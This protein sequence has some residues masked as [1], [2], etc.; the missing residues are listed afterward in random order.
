MLNKVLGLLL[1]VGVLFSS[2][3]NEPRLVEKSLAGYVIGTTYHI[4][5][6]SE[7]GESYQVQIDSVYDA[8]I[9][10]MSTYEPTSDISKI[11]NGDTNIVVDHMFVDVYKTS[12]KIWKETD[13]VFDPTIGIMVNAWGFGPKKQLNNLNKAK[14]IQLMKTVGFDK[15]RILS[16]GFF[17]KDFAETQIDFNAIAKGYTLDRVA[18]FFNQKGLENYLIEIG[19]EIVAKG[20]KLDGSKWRIGID[21][22]NQNEDRPLSAIVD[23]TDK[24][25]ATSGNYRRFRVDSLTGE[26][27][28]HTI[29]AKTGF[30]SRS[31]I[32][33]ASVMAD[34]C[35]LAD[36]YATT[37]MAMGLDDTK[38]FLSKHP[39]LEA[40]LIYVDE[41]GN[42]KKYMT[43]EFSLSLE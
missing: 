6:L 33:S 18:V 10:S 28:V 23:I 30:T 13:G 43:K 11:N 41:E 27:Y 15:T 42:W 5:Y 34:N 39:E 32:L 19:G 14:V 20:V 1:F 2:C 7:K 29:N 16:N 3:S 24:A 21:D 38:E 22:P 25:M 40:Y 35:T 26:K 9:K 31:N 4:K 8:I 36:G 37:F 17:Q 12:E